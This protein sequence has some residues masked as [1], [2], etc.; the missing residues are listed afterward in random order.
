MEKHWRYKHQHFGETNPILVS[1]FIRF[2]LWYYFWQR[3]PVFCMDV[4]VWVF[5]G[6]GEWKVSKSC[7]LAQAW[8]GYTLK[9]VYLFNTGIS[10]GHWMGCLQLRLSCW[11]AN[12]NGNVYCWLWTYLRYWVK[13]LNIFFNEITFCFLFLSVKS[14]RL[15][16]SFFFWHLGCTHCINS[17]AKISVFIKEC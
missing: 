6:C 2:C 11:W 9:V 14:E 3:T 5:I 16:F 1:N 12:S 13:L 10:W 8:S 7:S 4:H 15:L 17:W